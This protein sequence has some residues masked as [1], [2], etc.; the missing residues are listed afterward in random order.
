MINL[1]IKKLL[2]EY[3]NHLPIESQK[4]VRN[5]AHALVISQSKGTSGKDLL[6]FSGIMDQ[7]DID[8]M[9]EAI[10]DCEKVDQSGW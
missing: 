10:G 1:E 9:K 7:N 5:F 6:K 3:L 4:K 2:I 8:E